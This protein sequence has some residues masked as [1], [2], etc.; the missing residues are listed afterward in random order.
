MKTKKLNKKLWADFL[1]VYAACGADGKINKKIMLTAVFAVLLLNAGT[2]CYLAIKNQSTETD[3]LEDLLQMLL[4][5]ILSS[6]IVSFGV[7]KKSPDQQEKNQ[8]DNND[9]SSDEQ[10]MKGEK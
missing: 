4:L 9:T 1:N 2:I 10:S 8:N 3:L 6:G 5:L 7:I